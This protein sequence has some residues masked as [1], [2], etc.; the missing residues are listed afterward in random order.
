[1]EDLYS[2]HIYSYFELGVRST[3]HKTFRKL[4]E[5]INHYTIK[6][7]YINQNIV[8]LVSA[9]LTLINDS[10]WEQKRLAKCG[11]KSQPIR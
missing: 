5:N 2:W 8:T 9:Q 11:L 1:M 6:I 10:I 4:G 7:R 3:G